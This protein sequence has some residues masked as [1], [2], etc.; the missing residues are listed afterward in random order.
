MLLSVVK[1]AGTRQAAVAL[2]GDVA[3]ERADDL[4]LGAT[5][6]GATRDAGTGDDRRP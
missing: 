6:D 3:F 1:R 4:A 2:A 5:F